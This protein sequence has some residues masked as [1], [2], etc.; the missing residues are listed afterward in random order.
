MENQLT[1]LRKPDFN[2]LASAIIEK[3]EVRIQKADP[4]S[5]IN[6]QALVD[7][8]AALANINNLGI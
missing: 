6:Q 7:S 3:E 5:A 4:N 8:N 1:V 2:P